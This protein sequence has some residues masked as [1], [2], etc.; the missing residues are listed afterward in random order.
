MRRDNWLEEPA[1]RVLGLRS[2]RA[3]PVGH[4]QA[5]QL[6]WPSPS[7]PVLGECSLGKGISEKTSPG[8]LCH[9]QTPSP[10][11]VS[12]GPS[13]PL[14]GVQEGPGPLRAS[15]LNA[16]LRPGGGGACIRPTAPVSFLLK[17]VC[18][19][20]GS[21]APLWVPTFPAAWGWKDITQ[22]K[23]T[24][25]PMSLCGLSGLEVLCVASRADGPSVTPDALSSQ[26]TDPCGRRAGSPLHQE[27]RDR[28]LAVAGVG[29]TPAPPARLP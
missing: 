25:P 12:R 6:P 2:P 23:T 18:P 28:L 1:L 9:S 19:E 11:E 4:I 22:N 20:V 29:S 8:P 16:C 5:P 21:E 24:S 15:A 27:A 7:Q 3:V 10:R 14:S 13:A 17:A 26:G